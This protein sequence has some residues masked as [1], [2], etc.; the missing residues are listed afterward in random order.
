MTHVISTFKIEIMNENKSSFLDVISGN[1]S[2]KIDISLT[3]ATIGYL[4]AAAM[5]VGILLILIS[6]R[7]K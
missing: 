3:W 4:F 1:E 7:I 5:I 2:F 6:K